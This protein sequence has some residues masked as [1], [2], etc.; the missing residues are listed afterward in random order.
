MVEVDSTFYGL[1]P[2]DRFTAWRDRT[3]EDFL[4]TL[5]MPGEVTHEVALRDVR[6]AHRFCEDARAL[7][8]KLG[9]ILIQ[10]PPS[11]GPAAFDVTAAFLQ[12]LPDDLRFAIEFRDRAWLVPETRAMLREVGVTLAV[13]VGPWLDD[14]EARS[15]ADELAR[16]APSQ[17]H[18]SL[19]YLRW[20]EPPSRG[21][22]PGQVLEDRNG[23]IRSWAE[24]LDRAEVGEVLAFFNNDYQGHSPASARYLQSCL[25]QQPVP[26]SE[27][28]PQKEL[29]G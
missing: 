6:L 16:D 5:K 21:R 17:G 1:P 10:L 27:L 18:G 28:S 23:E 22:T 29:F 3:P 11:H 13:S 26:P 14:D 7:G 12:R 24:L 9:P 15:L 4:F 19:L 20:L 8:P 2:A 25:G